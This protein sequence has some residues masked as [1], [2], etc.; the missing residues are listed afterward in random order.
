[1]TH[2]QTHSYTLKQVAAQARKRGEH[3]LAKRAQE[4]ANRRHRR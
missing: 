3:D 2:K 4:Y 1:M